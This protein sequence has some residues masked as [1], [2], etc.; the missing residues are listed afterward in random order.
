MSESGKTGKTAWRIGSAGEFCSETTQKK[1]GHRRID[2][3]L[4]KVCRQGLPETA[5]KPAGGPE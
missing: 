1:S 4:R 2:G 3:R 5:K